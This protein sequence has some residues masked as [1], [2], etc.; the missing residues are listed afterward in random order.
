MP[1]NPSSE[2][3]PEEN[4]TESESEPEPMSRA[5]RRAAAR[6]KGTRTD[7]PVWNAGKVTGARGTPAA[8]RSFS[9]RRSG[10]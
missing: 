4:P 7:A 3:E 2:A 8:R 5:E 1:A 9:S 10:G 6:G